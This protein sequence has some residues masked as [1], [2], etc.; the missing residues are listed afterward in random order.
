VT[1]QNN[2]TIV[3]GGLLSENVERVE[4]KVPVLGDL[5]FLGKF[6]TSDALQRE[7]RVVMI[8]V[9]ARVVD[10]GGKPVRN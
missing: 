4:D 10:P 2:R 3:I 1:V 5:P 8:F 9:T 6:F 7:K